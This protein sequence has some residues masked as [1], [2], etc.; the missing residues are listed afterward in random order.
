LK[1]RELIQDLMTLD[2][3]AEVILSSDEE[4]NGFRR[5]RDWIEGMFDPSD[6]YFIESYVSEDW[7]EDY[8]P[9][10]WNEILEKYAPCVIIFP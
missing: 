3:E 8:D 6:Q 2:P 4:G 1:V 7:E 10:E 5:S 9:Q